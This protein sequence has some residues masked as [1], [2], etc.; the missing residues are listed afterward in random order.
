MIKGPC[1]VGLDSLVRSGNIPCYWDGA[2]A[3]AALN[4]LNMNE[5]LAHA[6]DLGAYPKNTE[7]GKRPKLHQTRTGRRLTDA[8]AATPAE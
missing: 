3:E 7:Q 8:R 6:S 5:E 2:S 1:Y 4:T